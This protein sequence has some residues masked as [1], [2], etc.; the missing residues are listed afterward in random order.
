M[1]GGEVRGDSRGTEWGPLP[2][3]YH[4]SSDPGGE[5]KA[6]S[7]PDPRELRDECL[8]PG[9]REYPGWKYLETLVMG[10]DWLQELCGFG[11]SGW[12]GPELTQMWLLGEAGLSNH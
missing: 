12:S 3:A 11:G 8:S 5:P 7:E 10:N 2:G 9:Q 6:M 4:P 1:T